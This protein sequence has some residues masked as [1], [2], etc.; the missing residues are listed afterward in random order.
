M[1]ES[2]TLDSPR[3]Q[4]NR[5]VAARRWTHGDIDLLQHLLDQGNATREALLA[6]DPVLRERSLRSL[7]A[8]GLAA[9]KDGTVGLSE[10]GKAV[11]SLILDQLLRKKARA[12]ARNERHA[13]AR[14]QVDTVKSTVIAAIRSV[15]PEIPAEVAE[16]V[17]L[18]ITPG[19]VKSGGRR[20]GMQT[21]V[22]AVATVRF[23]RWRQAVAAEP[24]VS[25]RLTAMT[26]RGDNNRARKR[27]RDQRAADRVR[28]ELETWRGELPPVETRRLG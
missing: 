1:T 18:R 14:E 8:I 16:A 21:V 20:P 2:G 6:D 5:L 7:L 23:E 10:E 25:T 27:Y 12:T 3:D 22:D 9:E 17:A 19:V 13:E 11:A 26:A 28:D 24:E 15:F 4:A